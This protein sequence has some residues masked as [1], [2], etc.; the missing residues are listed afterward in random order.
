MK[1]RNLAEEFCV[2]A[3]EFSDLRDLMNTP[4]RCRAVRIRSSKVVEFCLLYVNRF[5]L[6]PRTNVNT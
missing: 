2:V 3:G 4:I 5:C 1:E 6:R